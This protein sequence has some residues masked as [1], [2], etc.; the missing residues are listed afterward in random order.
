MS[1]SPS[2]SLAKQHIK[3]IKER[4]RSHR[5]PENSFTPAVMAE[6]TPRRSSM[7]T[8]KASK[9]VRDREHRRADRLDHYNTSIRRGPIGRVGFRL[10]SGR[11][12]GPG[13]KTEVSKRDPSA[14][15]PISV[16]RGAA[17]S[18]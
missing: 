4:T 15:S 16:A 7:P 1:P 12:E 9:M 6:A 8:A 2:P 10:V 3:P 14:P 11:G 13:S 17:M 18:D 5:E